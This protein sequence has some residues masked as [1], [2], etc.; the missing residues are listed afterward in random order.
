MLFLSSAVGWASLPPFD[1][2]LPEKRWFFPFAVRM[3][4]GFITCRHFR[5]G[6]E[7]EQC[8][9]VAFGCRCFNKIGRGWFFGGDFV[10]GC[11]WFGHGFLFRVE[12]ALAAAA[13]G[14]MGIVGFGVGAVVALAA[15]FV[16][17]EVL[18]FKNRSWRCDLVVFP[19]QNDAADIVVGHD[20]V[21]VAAHVRGGDLD[22]VEVHAGVTAVD[23]SGG[24]RGEDAGDGDLD[25]GAVFERGQVECDG[26]L[27]LGEVV[28][29]EVLVGKGGGAAAASAGADVTADFVHGYPLPDLYGDALFSMT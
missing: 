28:V 9:V 25:G 27:A 8:G 24:E 20:V 6:L 10:N 16:V 7:G 18:L 1:V 5:C 29:A 17:V 4:A 22:A 13:V 12:V 2:R 21:E 23:H 19:C 3:T 26:L 11:G 15:L 14:M